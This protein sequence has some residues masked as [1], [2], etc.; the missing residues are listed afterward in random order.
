[1]S[2]GVKNQ[3]E[4]HRACLAMREEKG[5]VD[6]SLKGAA[7]DAA[8]GVGAQVSLKGLRTAHKAV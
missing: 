4:L 3:L 5:S 7:P 2:K 6:A 1:M 8:A